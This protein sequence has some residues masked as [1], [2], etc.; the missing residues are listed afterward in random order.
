MQSF[1]LAPIPEIIFGNGRL[2]DLP[3]HVA[4][5][6][7]KAQPVMIVADPAMTSLGVT[8][9]LGRLLAEAG[10]EA[11]IYDGFKG[12]PR[13]ADIDRAASSARD[14]KAKAVIGLGGGTALDTAKLVAVCA[15]S[16]KP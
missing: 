10:H 8:A 12:E 9:K 4:R 3:S 16:G 6:A 7:G 15:V 5:R 14:M 11:Q 2:S 1:S 13:S